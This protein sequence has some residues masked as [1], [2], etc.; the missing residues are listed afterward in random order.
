MRS[1]R[2]QSRGLPGRLPA[3][4]VLLWQGQPQADALMRRMFHIAW[5]AA[6]FTVL[7]ILSAANAA[8]HGADLHRIT[9]A[10]LHRA[11]LACVPLVLISS[12]ACGIARTT[13]YSIT[14]RR[15]VISCGIALPITFNLPFSCLKAA[16]LRRYSGGSG[17]VVLELMEGEKLSYFAVWPHARPWHLAKLQPM[18]RC[19][20]DADAAAGHL[21][22]ALTEHSATPA[23]LPVKA[24]AQTQ[25]RGEVRVFGGEGVA[26]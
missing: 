22:G 4:E 25:A 16:S 1:L 8:V 17:D 5:V 15:V 19:V 11:E 26:A 6:Y 24:A 7:I 23:A 21:A 2:L 3:G 10:M 14:N 12:Y 9:W 18:L 20:A 13:T